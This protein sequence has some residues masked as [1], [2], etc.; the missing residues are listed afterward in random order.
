MNLANYRACCGRHVGIGDTCPTCGEV[1]QPF[2]AAVARSLIAGQVAKAAVDLTVALQQCAPFL[3]F[4]FVSD[5]EHGQHALIGRV[6]L[7]GGWLTI[8]VQPA[9]E[10]DEAPEGTPIAA[11][12]WGE[13]PNGNFSCG[14]YKAGTIA[15]VFAVGGAVQF[16]SS[17]GTPPEGS[18]RRDG[19]DK[20]DWLRR[21]HG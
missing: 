14:T 5:R 15:Q 10:F 2:R 17:H 1:A 16:A 19:E 20:D 13:H 6:P 4:D 18:E 7:C 21:V 9:T 3:T 11:V 12:N 8:R